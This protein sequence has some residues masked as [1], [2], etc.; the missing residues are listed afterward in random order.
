MDSP[1]TGVKLLTSNGNDYTE[2]YKYASKIVFF[3]DPTSYTVVKIAAVLDLITFSTY[4]ATAILFAVFSFI[5]TW[6][7]FL[8]FY[9]QYPHLHRSLAIASFFIPS[10]FFWGSGLL[11]DTLTL[12]F[13]GI[14][15]Y[16]AYK[17]FILRKKSLNHLALLALALY[18]LYA[19]KIYI[20]LIF[21]PAMIL[22]VF[23]ANF[24]SINSPVLK[25]MIFPFVIS[26][27]IMLSY[28]AMLKA[29]EDN[30]K[31]ALSSLAKTA[32]VTAYDIRYWTGRD[33]GSGY[34]LGE[35]DGT[36]MSM[37]KLAPQAINVSLFRPYLWEVRNPLMLLSAL[38][39]LFLLIF[40]LY[41]FI[42][43]NVTVI[44]AVSQ[45]NVLFAMVFSITFAFA[46]G[47]STFNFGTLVRYKIPL[48]PFFLV[49]LILTLHY[50]KSERKLE[51]LE[52]T[53]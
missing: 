5:G 6:M 28:Y 18:G 43:K 44:N 48:M 45:P 38:E 41:I 7:F 32:Q 35:L 8:T 2:V 29:G 33:A 26:A 17:I 25:I 46:V 42:K 27:A 11:K 10:V 15:T 20:L 50:S 22:W 3:T 40:C 53:E 21:L 39:S 9:E 24:Q 23:L 47:V 14:S 4:S 52:I 37:I 30:E 36:F 34:V 12:G 13:L 1:I 51:E 19:I 31:Y 49:T 16:Q